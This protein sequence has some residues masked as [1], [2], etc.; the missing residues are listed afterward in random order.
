MVDPDGMTIDKEGTLY[1]TGRGGIWA[2]CPDGTSLGM[3]PTSEFCSNLTFGGA[4][5]TTL[6]VT[7]DKT[8]YSLPMTISGAK[9]TY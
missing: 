9:S 2:I 7:C 1:V 5:G 8:L 3:I 4:D 6:Y